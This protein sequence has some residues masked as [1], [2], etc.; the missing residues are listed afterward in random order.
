MLGLFLS[1]AVRFPLYFALSRVSQFP[2]FFCLIRNRNGPVWILHTTNM[3]MTCSLDLTDA[4]TRAIPRHAR[5]LSFRNTTSPIQS[6]HHYQCFVFHLTS[7]IVTFV[8]QQHHRSD[9]SLLSPTRETCSVL[10]V[11]ISADQGACHAV[12]GS[13][14]VF[15]SR[16]G[17][18]HVCG[19]FLI[20]LDDTIY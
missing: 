14:P 1:L 17:C 10:Q 19:D 11:R 5:L 4:G 13:A 18:L 2:F 6:F 7:A 9:V 15:P 12:S 8:L 3:D 16:S 20:G